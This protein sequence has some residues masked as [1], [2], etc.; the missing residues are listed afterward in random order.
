MSAKLRSKVGSEISNRERRCPIRRG[1][2]FV[3]PI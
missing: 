1:D 2:G 3:D